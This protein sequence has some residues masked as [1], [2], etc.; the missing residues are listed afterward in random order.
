LYWTRASRRAGEGTRVVV[1]SVVLMRMQLL[2]VGLD[3]VVIGWAGAHSGGCSSWP[4][5]IW[6]VDGE[7]WF[8]PE[9][10]LG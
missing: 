10:I 2:C 4:V 9:R 7:S 6:N 5:L 1:C 3:L 8:C